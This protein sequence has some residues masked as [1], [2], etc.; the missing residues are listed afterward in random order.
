[1]VYAAR[2]YLLYCM[3]DTDTQV[4]PTMHYVSIVMQIRCGTLEI[5]MLTRCGILEIGMQAHLHI[6][7]CCAT[8]MHADF[9]FS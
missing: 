2:Q 1:M 3:A 6:V 8:T 4:Y 9:Y 5:G 7:Y